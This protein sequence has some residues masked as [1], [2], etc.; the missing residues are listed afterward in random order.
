[1][2][3]GPLK[4]G[5]QRLACHP[6]DWQAGST[7]WGK[8]S[9]L[10]FCSSPS[11][12]LRDKVKV[13][14]LDLKQAVSDR[15]GFKS[16]EIKQVLVPSPDTPFSDHRVPMHPWISM[17]NL[18]TKLSL[19]YDITFPPMKRWNL[20]L[21]PLIPGGPCEKLVTNKMWGK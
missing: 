18:F 19:Q 4:A 3:E 14:N 21:H 17:V 9:V 8:T 1:M 6:G 12:L 16:T 2:W 10:S 5:L 20:C 7:G 15:Y 13:G 11:H